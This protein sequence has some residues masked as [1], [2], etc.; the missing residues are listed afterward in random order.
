MGLNTELANALW[1]A[2]N[3]GAPVPRSKAG[4]LKS[5]ED[6]YQCQTELVALM[7]M[8]RA[9]WKIGA[10]NKAIQN[11]FGIEQPVS[12]PMF[13]QLCYKSGDQVGIFVTPSVVIECEFAFRFADDLPA[14]QGPYQ[15]EEVLS[16]VECV[17]P[18]IEVV[19]CRFEGGFRD[20]GATLLTADLAAHCAWIGGTPHADWHQIDFK[21]QPV[22][23]YKDS[24]KVREGIGANALGDP[25]NVL[26][27]LANHLSER[28]IGL[29]AGEVVSTGTCT[30]IFPVAPKDE[31]VVDFAELGE[32]L[33]RFV[34]HE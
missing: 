2:R 13:R 6:A 27:W 3:G 19:D 7:G 17:I 14:R 29:K 4:Y 24:V 30:D 34:E 22:T 15:R 8:E 23:L 32:V 1:Q 26:E 33:V 21:T 5:I 12:G 11:T 20:I 25:L 28:G 18:S 9:G 10:T 31:L 16:A